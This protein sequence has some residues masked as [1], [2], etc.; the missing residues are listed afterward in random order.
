MDAAMDTLTIKKE[1]ILDQERSFAR[2]L[3]CAVIDVPKLSMWMILI[4]FILVYHVYRH[5][6]AM[7]GRT[8]FAAHYLLSRSRSLEEACN[9]LAE[10]R[11]PDIDA[12]VAKAV[13]LPETARPPYQAWI[14]VL[15]RHYADLLQAPGAGFRDLI[16][17]VYRNRSNYLI[18]LNQLNNLERTLNTALKNHVGE[19][20]ESV[21]DTIARIEDYS[22]R[23][24]RLQAEAL[25]P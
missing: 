24:R 2:D 8:A 16:Q 18:L 17:S 12:V 6:S 3:A 22:A 14:T 4:P 7:K 25:F 10:Q 9:A 19:A 21:I 20:A 5:N 13:D 1:W 23:L 11:L 15:I